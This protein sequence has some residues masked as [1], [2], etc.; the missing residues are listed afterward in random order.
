MILFF[1]RRRGRLISSHHLSRAGPYFQL[2]GA[3]DPNQDDDSLV[4]APF[5]LSIPFPAIDIGADK[6]FA[7]EATRAPPTSAQ[8]TQHLPIMPPVRC[9]SKR[10]EEKRRT[11]SSLDHIHQAEISFWSICCLH[12][13]LFVYETTCTFF[14]CGTAERENI[15]CFVRSIA[16]LDACLL[17]AVAHPISSHLQHRTTSG[18]EGVETE[19]ENA[20]R[21]AWPECRLLD[22]RKPRTAR[23]KRNIST[24]G[25]ELQ[26]N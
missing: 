6:A 21:G 22:E 11:Y 15:V 10:R 4:P 14:F 5:Y 1:S 9:S 18:G 20:H 26:R 2:Q 13:L 25:G 3:R 7:P 17:V 23:A 12:S 24:D 16:N 8:L 19:K